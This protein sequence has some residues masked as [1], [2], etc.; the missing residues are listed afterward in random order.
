[1]GLLNFIK[2]SGKGLINEG[3]ILKNETGKRPDKFKKNT[4]H[5]SNNLVAYPVDFLS[6]ITVSYVG[7]NAEKRKRIIAEGMPILRR[8]IDHFKMCAKYWEKNRANTGKNSEA[9]KHAQ[10][11]RNKT[12]NILD[13][14]HQA[15]T[16]LKEIEICLQHYNIKQE[17]II[18][19]GKEKLRE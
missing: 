15:K 8:Q 14:I 11:F 7:A 16:A 17:T 9:Y 6:S 12:S 2:A 4:Y 18:S 3:G 1:M 13:T 10:Y 19:N 5:P